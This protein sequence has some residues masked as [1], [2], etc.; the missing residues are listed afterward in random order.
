MKYSR[1]A[2]L[3]IWALA[4]FMPAGNRPAKCV[5]SQSGITSLQVVDDN[6]AY[7]LV[8][9]FDKHF[10]NRPVVV[11]M[12]QN[13]EGENAVVSISATATTEL[14]ILTVVVDPVKVGQDGV[15]DIGWI[16]ND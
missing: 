6:H 13:S 5:E 4:L 16:G 14:V 1:L 8:V 12:E 7:L 15:V 10:C 11:A 9:D 3:G 2:A